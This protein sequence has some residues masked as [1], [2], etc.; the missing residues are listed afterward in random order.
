[1]STASQVAG[2]RLGRGLGAVVVA[3]VRTEIGGKD[4]FAL[5]DL[6]RARQRAQLPGSRCAGS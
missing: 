3:W 1:V 2:F 6:A 5:A 4:R